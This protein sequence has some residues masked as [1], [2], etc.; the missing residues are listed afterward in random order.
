MIIDETKY[1]RQKLAAERWRNS[2]GIGC[3]NLTPRFGKTYLAIHFIIN[4][5]LT[6]SSLNNIIILVHSE[7]IAKHWKDN[8]NVHGENLNDRVV[9]YTANS[10]NSSDQ[11]NCTLLIVDEPQKFITDN[12]KLMVDGSIIKHTYR[13]ALSG[14]PPKDQWFRELYPIVDTI[15]EDE[16]I[17]RCWIAKFVEY[18]YLLDLTDEDKIRYSTFSEPISETLNLFRDKHKLFARPGGGYIF[19]DDF[20]LIRSCS[21]GKST[22]NLR[23]DFIYIMYDQVCNT[24]ATL[25][26]WSTNVD[27]T[28]EYGKDRND[29]WNPNAIHTRAKTFIEF[30]KKRND[31]LINNSIKLNAVKEIVS[32]FHLTTICFNE[33][34]DFVEKVN[35]MVNDIDNFKDY[36]SIAYHSKIES[37]PIIDSNTGEFYKYKSGT[38]KG[39]PKLFGQKAI[40]DITIEGVRNGTYQFLSTAKS[41]DEGL[42]IPSIEQVI[43]TAG[44]TNPMTYQQRTARGKTVD[45]YNPNK[46]TKIFNLVFD[47]FLDKDDKLIKS[48][49]KQKLIQRQHNSMNNI[50]W[51]K[52]INEIFDVNEE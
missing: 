20:D 1:E 34:I 6:K 42:D 44:S 32:A 15:T 41:L 13:L 8:L 26:G 29:Y 16:A 2:K 27:I 14:T 12:R 19:E 18:N 9:I 38:K 5:H 25:M 39:E 35:D 37:R 48:R 50:Q 52:S 49:D 17:D 22:P 51:I 43:C 33:S 7:V 31:I 4:A 28:T 47:D 46:V 23:G 21:S 40:K 45:I 11:L 24:L 3:L 36:K 30:I 10:L